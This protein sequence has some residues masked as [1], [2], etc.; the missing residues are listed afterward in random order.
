MWSIRSR[1]RTVCDRANNKWVLFLLVDDD[2]AILQFPI[3]QSF[4]SGQILKVGHGQ[5]PTREDR[6]F[7]TQEFPLY[8]DN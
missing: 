7:I 3:T 6:E 1:I 5:E 2:E 4:D 8:R